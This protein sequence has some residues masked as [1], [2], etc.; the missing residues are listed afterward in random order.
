MNYRDFGLQ[1]DP[2][3]HLDSTKDARLYEYLVIPKMVEVVWDDAPVAIFA[4]PGGGKSALRTYIEKAYRRTR[5]VKLPVTYIPSIYS[6][7]PNFHDDG[8][9]Q[10]L[11]RSIFIYIISYP[12]LFLQFSQAQQEK[13]IQLFTHLPFDLNFLLDV[14]Q[15]ATSIAEIEQFLGIGAISGIQ[16]PGQAHY[17]MIELIRNHRT[18]S[19]T[20]VTICQLFEQ[21]RD[22]F[23]IKSF[24]VLVDGLDGFIETTPRETLIAWVEP[25]LALADVL[26]KQNIYLKLFIPL[27]L[28][29]FPETH[30]ISSLQT[31]VLEWDA[32]LLAEVI[33]RRLYIASGGAFNSLDALS[34]PGLRNVEFHLA[35]Q[36]DFENKLPRQIIK[37]VRF[38]LER[39][40]QNPDHYIHYN[41][42]YTGEANDVQTIC[43]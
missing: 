20:D 19:T 32:D 29:D 41:D 23:E 25:L 37:A 8:L 12:E 22:I 43:A 5:G 6:S 3:A 39:A 18:R 1:F 9:K 26:I 10:A 13:T 27:T 11:A 4:Q 15:S 35:Q 42:V 2:F 7:H 38:L 31:A 40:S 17:E 21:A 16:K 34:I 28:A 36:L 30:P 24:H 33:Q 14:S